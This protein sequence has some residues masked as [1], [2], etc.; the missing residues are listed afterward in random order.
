MPKFK[1]WVERTHKRRKLEKPINKES[2]MDLSKWRKEKYADVMC[3]Y[4][5]NEDERDVY[6]ANELKKLGERSKSYY[7]KAQF[8]RRAIYLLLK[9]GSVSLKEMAEKPQ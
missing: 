4:F 5:K 6:V 2:N 1:F 3:L 7:A 8:I 9:N